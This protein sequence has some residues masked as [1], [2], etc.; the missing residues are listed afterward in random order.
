MSQKKVLGRGLGAL[1]PEKKKAEN[2]MPSGLAELLV[3]QIVPNRY[4]PRKHF[5]EAAIEDLAR[6]IVQHGVMQ[7]IVVSRVGENRYELIAGERRFRAAQKAG[8]LTVPA[9]IKEAVASG[10]MLQLAIIENVQR[11]DLNPIEEAVAYEQLH[12][13]FALTQDEIAKRVG[14]ERSTVANSLRLLR[15]PDSVKQLVA[16]R[17]LSMGHARAL[18]GA[19]DPARIEKL[20]ARVVEQGLN[21]RQTEKLLAPEKKAKK[22]ANLKDVF[23]RDAEDKLTR[24]MRT[25]VEIDRKTRGGTIQIHF[26]SEDELIRI[27]EDINGRKR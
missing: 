17:Q 19:S 14:R 21:V 18:L 3:G 23:T 24:A 6:S 10:D 20:A 8:L 26:T 9:V 12:S 13:E 25:R 7:P 2:A 16:E 15:L 22:S 27:F 1:I 5:D 4:Q 11:E